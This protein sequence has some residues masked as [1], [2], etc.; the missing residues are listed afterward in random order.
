ME[1]LPQKAN[2]VIHNLCLFLKL[3]NI[4][5]I[6]TLIKKPFKKNKNG[7]FNRNAPI[8]TKPFTSEKMLPMLRQQYPIKIETL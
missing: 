7:L 2:Q 8:P 4:L 3:L 6:A 1:F 5:I